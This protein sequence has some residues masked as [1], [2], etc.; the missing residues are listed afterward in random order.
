MKPPD[1]LQADLAAR[2][3]D[4][5][6]DLFVPFQPAEGSAESRD[7]ATR[8]NN[9][10]AADPWDGRISREAHLRMLLTMRAG[11]YVTRNL[12]PILD[13]MRAIKSPAEI[14]RHR[15]GDPNRRRS[16]HGGD[17]QH[18]AWRRRA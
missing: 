2:Y 16:D 15:P 6:R 7:G 3:K 17:A 4:G 8:R 12:S 9:D 14:A 10:A 13:E 11:N 18:R 5:R 1:A